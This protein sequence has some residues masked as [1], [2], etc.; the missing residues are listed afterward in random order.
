M[1]EGIPDEGDDRSQMVSTI[2]AFKNIVRSIQSEMTEVKRSCDVCSVDRNAD[3]AIDTCESSKDTDSKI[4]QQLRDL[5]ATVRSI[6]ASLLQLQN[7]VN[8]IGG[9]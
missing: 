5:K 6:D 1:N 2:L 4:K 9:W 8:T 7:T 3:N